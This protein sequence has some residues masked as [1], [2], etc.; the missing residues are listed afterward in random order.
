MPERI[1]PIC[2]VVHAGC[3]IRRCAAQPRAHLCRLYPLGSLYISTTQ[4]HQATLQTRLA[5]EQTRL[6]QEQTRPAQEQARSTQRVAEATI[7]QAELEQGRSALL[8]GEPDASIHLARVYQH[9]DHS[10]LFACW[11]TSSC[12][13]PLEDKTPPMLRV[14]PSTIRTRE[15]AP[16]CLRRL[17]WICPAIWRSRPCLLEARCAVAMFLAEP[18]RS[19]ITLHFGGSVLALDP[20][21]WFVNGGFLL[22]RPPPA[23]SSSAP[24]PPGSAVARARHLA[25]P[26][27]GAI[28]FV[29]RF[30]SLVNLNVHVHLL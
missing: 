17:Q 30:G 10:R 25:A 5:Q 27:T 7:T 29:Q 22:A 28:T 1:T 14:R 4:A 6:A 8:H 20:D 11:P 16:P 24:S 26:Q 12:R 23:A 19:E 15:T 18:W 2:S 13:A 21:H 3:A 9:G